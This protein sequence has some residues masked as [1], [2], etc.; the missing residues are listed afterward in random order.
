MKSYGTIIVTGGSY[1][2]T[3]YSQIQIKLY[4]YASKGFSGDS[5]LVEVSTDNGASWGTAGTFTRGASFPA[6]KTW[7]N[8]SV[9]WNKPAGVTSLR[10]RIRTTTTVTKSS[11]GK[12]NLENVSMDGR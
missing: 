11:K 5:I 7:Y 6:D 9:I 4:C 12:V 10:L 8:P 1:D 3:N 2:V